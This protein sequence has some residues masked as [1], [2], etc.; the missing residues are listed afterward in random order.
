MAQQRLLLWPGHRPQFRPFPSNS[1]LNN[2][3]HRR[4][5]AA[6]RRFEAS[7]VRFE[8][9]NRRFGASELGFEASKPRF[10]ASKPGFEA[11]KRRFGASKRRFEASKRR[12]EASRHRFEASKRRYEA[13]KPRFEA[14]NARFEASES[15]QNGGS[16]PPPW[17]RN[18]RAGH[19][20][21]P[22]TLEPK[23]GSD[24]EIPYPRSRCSCPGGN[25]IVG[26][27]ESADDFAA[28]P[29][30]AADLKVA[31]DGYL[32]TRDKASVAD[33]AAAE[34]HGEKDEA[35]EAL[36]DSLRADPAVH[37]GGR[38][39]RR[40]EAAKAG[41]GRSQAAHVSRAAG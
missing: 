25:V 8:G 9:S 19:A 31:L 36:I 38:E 39:A 14:W 30:P 40:R 35:L 23:R 2:H 17:V 6:D 16:R 7:K 4:D 10:G 15:C 37:R 24:Y 11:S 5:A 29:I 1:L 41:L 20:Q 26:L 21:H 12:F 28:P 32:A 13:S 22:H 33:G 34:A 18:G 27:T 3:L